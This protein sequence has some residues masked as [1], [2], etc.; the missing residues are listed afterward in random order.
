MSAIINGG[1]EIRLN[2]EKRRFL[3]L[4]SLFLVDVLKNGNSDKK[5]DHA[6][7]D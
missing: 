6:E 1:G 7:G 5:S 3:R 2:I 4:F